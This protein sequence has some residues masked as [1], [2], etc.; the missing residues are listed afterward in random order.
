MNGVGGHPFVEDGD[1]G[2]VRKDD[3]VFLGEI[4]QHFGRNQVV[5]DRQDE[6][7]ARVGTGPIGFVS[8][9]VPGHHSEA[10]GVLALSEGNLQAISEGIAAV[11]RGKPAVDVKLGV[12]HLDIVLDEGPDGQV[13]RFLGAFVLIEA[14]LKGGADPVDVEGFVVDH[15]EAPAS[16]RNIGQTVVNGDGA[17]VT[18]GDE[19]G[20]EIFHGS[21]GS[22][23]VAVW[24]DGVNARIGLGEFWAV[25]VF[26]GKGEP[27]TVG[28]GLAPSRDLVFTRS[29]RMG[30]DGSVRSIRLNPMRLVT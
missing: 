13:G 12:S 23:E 17:G 24:T 19:A 14:D 8:S 18:G 28:H 9:G 21:A 3:L 6:F 7:G 26:D 27:R 20:L 1:D 2:F 15:L 5:Y 22:Q 10:K 4:G 30:S 25:P 29:A 16:V 11:G